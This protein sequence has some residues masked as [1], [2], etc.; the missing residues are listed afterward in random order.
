MVGRD[1]PPRRFGVT[2]NNEEAYPS[3]GRAAQVE[4]LL[5]A[6]V[7]SPTAQ[8]DPRSL[9]LKRSKTSLTPLTRRAYLRSRGA[10]WGA[11]GVGFTGNNER[12][13]PRYHGS[14]DALRRSVGYFVVRDLRAGS[15]SRRWTLTPAPSRAGGLLVAR[16][17]TNS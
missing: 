14:C 5:A 1:S 10:S 7:S 2:I 16:P 15:P 3:R 17:G 13:H 8:I 9:E 4:A 11:Q 6:S 12:L